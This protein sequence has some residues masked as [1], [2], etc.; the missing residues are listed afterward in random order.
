M[1]KAT[2]GTILGNGKTVRWHAAD[3]VSTSIIQVM[4]IDDQGHRD[5]ALIEM[6]VVNKLNLAPQISNIDKSAAYQNTGKPIQ[7]NC[8]AADPNGD[9][10]AF[11]WTASGG[12]FSSTS[13]KSVVWT[14][15]GKEAIYTITVKVNDNG[16]LSDAIT[17]SI[18]VRNFA[19]S[20]EKLIAWYPFENNA[21]D[22]TVNQLHGEASGAV[23]VPDRNGKELSA[24][25]FNGG[26]QHIQVNNCLLYTSRCV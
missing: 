10:L 18:L 7:L 16:N 5:S 20:P 25:Y 22:K 9:S 19:D 17:T 23:Y 14:A 26:A 21:N 12:T 11:T 4:A 6:I 8:I 3:S 2:N 1:W 15:P 13:T 24:A